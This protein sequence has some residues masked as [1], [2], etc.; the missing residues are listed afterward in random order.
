[1]SQGS[2]TQA[3][4]ETDNGNV[5]PIK[6]QPETI[7]AV[8]GTANGQATGD[9]EAGFPSAQVGKGRRTIGI[10]ARTVT[11]RFDTPPSGY[12]ENGVIRIPVLVRNR[13]DSL[14]KGQAV[15][16]L[17][18]AATVVGKSPEKIN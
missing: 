14:T 13:W 11:I 2:F 1:M 9:V 17:S 16:Y 12:L 3:K 8:L 15:T 7:L 5:V 18:T 4:Y 6:V 10:N